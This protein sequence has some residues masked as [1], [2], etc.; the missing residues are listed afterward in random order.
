M[1]LKLETRLREVA[2]LKRL[3]DIKWKKLTPETQGVAEYEAKA[4]D[5]RMYCLKL[6]EGYVIITIGFK[7]N[8]DKNISR[9]RGIKTRY[10]K[11]R[12][13]L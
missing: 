4:D 5:L 9:M 7:G 11:E 2:E 13:A 3:P 10:L 8:Q 1:L 12:K 6:P